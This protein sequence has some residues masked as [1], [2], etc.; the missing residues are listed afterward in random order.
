[1][2]VNVNRAFSRS[3]F[4]LE[5]VALRACR[6]ILI[7]SL[8]AAFGLM[9]STLKAQTF[10][11]SIV[12]TVI[13]TAGSAV[14]GA[15][16][17]VINP[18]TNDKQTVKTGAAG[19][20]RFVNLVPSTYRVEVAAP[21]FKRF[22]QASVTVQVNTTSRVDAKLEVG[23]VT[24]TIE[25]TTAT[26]L[27]QTDSGTIGSEVQGAVVNEMPLSGRNTMNLVA[28]VPGVVAQGLSGGSALQQNNTTQSHFS[29][30]GWGNY[31][32]GGGIARMN[33]VYIDGAPANVLYQDVVGLIPTQDATQEFKVDTNNISAEFGRF[34]GGVIEMTTKSGTNAYHASLYEYFRN[35]VL[36][37]NLFFSN[38][39]G[40]PRAPLHQNQ[41]GLTASAPIKK[42]KVFGF[43]SWEDFHLRTVNPLLSNMPGDGN[44]GTVNMR[45]GIFSKPITDPAKKC[46]IQANTPQVGQYTIPQSCFDP[47]SKI[48]MGVY[49]PTNSTPGPGSNFNYK[50]QPAIGGNAYQYN[51]RVDYN[52]S[53]KQRMFGRYTYWNLL[54]IPANNFNDYGGFKTK[55]A[56]SYWRTHGFV[57]GD[58]YTLN[59]AT[60]F[61]ARLSYM[62]ANY[63]A[64]G[65]G[66]GATDMTQFGPAYT[67]LA[68]Q[69]TYS[70]IPGWG[71]SG[72]NGIQ[73]LAGSI[74]IEQAGYNNY[75][76][77]PSM[78]KIIGPHSLKFGG[79]IRLAEREGIGNFQ[80]LP[81]ASY[82]ST[83]V[84]DEFAA[85]LLGEFSKDAVN[86]VTPTTTFNYSY[87]LY[88]IDTWQVNRKLT[89]SL[90]VRWELPG[91]MEE[92]K[93]RTTVLLPNTVDPVTGF[94]GAIA[95]VN[96]SLYP[97]RSMMPPR[98]S[99][100][101]PRIGVAYRLDTS[102][103]VRGGYGIVR[104]GP[105]QPSG[106]VAFQSPVSAAL[107]TSV[108]NGAAP[109][110]FQA[111]PFPTTL[112]GPCNTSSCPQTILQ[113]T[114]RSNPNFSKN[115]VGQV[116]GSAVPSTNFPY[117][118]QW[119]VSFS[120]QW[121]GD[122]LTEIAYVGTTGTNLV[123]NGNSSG[124]NQVGINQIPDGTYN[125]AG[126]A[127]SGPDTGLSLT[128][129]AVNSLTPACAAWGT[130][131]GKTPTVGQCLRPYP[132]FQDY[133]NTADYRG[134]S[135]YNAMQVNVIKRF[136]TGGVLNA[137][138]AWAKMESNTDGINNGQLEK[139][140]GGIGA[141][142][143]TQNFNNIDADRSLFPFN[144]AHRAVIS[145]V[146]D[147]PFGQGRRYAH[148][149]G[150]AGVLV[151]GW[152]VNGV[153]MFQAGYP[154]AFTYTSNALNQTLGAGVLRPNYVAGCNKTTTGTRYERFINKN[155][156][157]ASC[158]TAP[159]T[160]SFGNQP[161]VDPGLHS[162]GIDNFDFSVSKSSKIRERAELDFRAEF[163][164]LFNHTQFA[165]PGTQLAGSNFDAISIQANTSRIVQLSLRLEF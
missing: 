46:A 163:F 84:G 140:S 94:K 103:V 131:T 56:P 80:E 89:L 98:H 106:I 33:A 93:D 7:A 60:V 6:V 119:N 135:N 22:A 137:N 2:E 101:D 54:N 17:T 146:L 96:S 88:G 42:D 165:S 126:V 155:W 157:N 48:L 78:T 44:N 100:F 120:H 12:G 142:G 116:V 105:D 134:E 129:K 109:V 83:N 8:A 91:G 67:S 125:S 39:A 152:G 82:V 136:G 15:T 49:P 153:T 95:L 71:L 55:G 35:T 159:G 40:R 1:V 85:F 5:K 58:A 26:P 107:T 114:G 53:E 51:A 10:Y 68:S 87:A 151:S 99:L 111:N 141:G 132:Q 31:Q 11:G 52:I 110:Y 29:Y 3:E 127:T 59:S 61:D 86:T 69:V 62:W 164:N 57:I 138:Y 149:S 81:M 160:Y 148:F 19:E 73:N 117:I 28:L 139:T 72:S 158:F 121:K 156:F 77:N 47:T 97:S 36:N 75:T 16:V 122:W 25:V 90:G 64:K 128:A 124:Y 130:A 23:A 43:F 65:E 113:P 30:T 123:L 41:F 4:W 154:L 161:R 145:Y 147:L 108:N 14:S 45:A 20:Y 92:K 143:Y 79:E 21:S 32:I 104:G 118:Q 63:T 70:S 115:W 66:V 18:H 34:S 37:A 13:D 50:I 133:L 24:E 150:P 162:Q 102:T 27:L 144:V 38:F 112:G 76:L 9:P 74:S